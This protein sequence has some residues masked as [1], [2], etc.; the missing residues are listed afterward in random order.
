MPKVNLVATLEANPGSEENVRTTLSTVEAASQQEEGCRRYDVC[1]SL[2]APGIFVVVE[3][4]ADAGALSSH[5]A[6]PHF[7]TAMATLDGHVVRAS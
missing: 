7:K 6:S 4:W 1:E 5:M 2:S 3:E